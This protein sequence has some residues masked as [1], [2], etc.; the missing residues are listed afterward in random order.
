MSHVDHSSVFLDVSEKKI[1]FALVDLSLSLLSVNIYG[2][3]RENAE[4]FESHGQAL[5]EGA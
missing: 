1:D 3:K 4:R 2:V 5:R